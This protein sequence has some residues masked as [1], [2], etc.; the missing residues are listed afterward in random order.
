MEERIL[1]AT[2]VVKIYDNNKNQQVLSHFNGTDDFLT[3]FRLFTEN[4]FQNI[5]QLPDLSGNR[6]IHLTLEQP[7]ITNEDNRYIYGYFSSGVGGERYRL[8]N[9]NTN[10]TEMDVDTHHA[11]FRNVFFYFYVPKNRNI[12]YLILQRKQHFGIK[13]KLIPA[14][15]SYIRQRGYYL[16]NVHINNLV[17]NSVYNRM[18]RDGNLK[19]VEL[20]KRRIPRS[21]EAYIEG[22]EQLEEINGTYRSSF[23]SRTSLPQNWKDFIDRIFKQQNSENATL[24]IQDLDENINDLE[25]ELELNGKKKTFYVVNRQRIQPDIDVTRNIEFVNDEPSTDSLIAQAI[26][27]INEML[28]ITPNNV[29]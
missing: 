24:D 13:T 6:T 11:A 8:V 7:A 18:M 9:T 5:N 15:N 29:E 19:K 16:Y 23:T 17:H 28:E 1:L 21:L 2:Y 26:E 20:V 12:G 14:I 10:E 27:L 22:N 25:F 3:T 4:I